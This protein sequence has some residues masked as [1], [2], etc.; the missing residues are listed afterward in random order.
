MEI[1]KGRSSEL[2]IDWEHEFK[3]RYVYQADDKLLCLEPKVM[4][5]MSKKILEFG[6]SK[7]LTS[8][9]KINHKQGESEKGSETSKDY[10]K[11]YLDELEKLKEGLTEPKG[12]MQI[13][14]ISNTRKYKLASFNSS[15]GQSCQSK[16]SQLPHSQNCLVAQPHSH[17]FGQ[18]GGGSF[19]MTGEE[20]APFRMLQR[21][22]SSLFQHRISPDHWR[23]EK[24]EPTKTSFFPDKAT[25]NRITLALQDL[26]RKTEFQQI[27][28]FLVSENLKTVYREAITKTGEESLLQ[29]G[30]YLN[31]VFDL[32]ALFGT[33]RYVRFL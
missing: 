17:M 31:K 4:S 14:P 33:L 8:F 27:P 29:L 13:E 23:S 28:G 19:Q 12:L 32:K 11:A 24:K 3:L 22:P 18:F 5:G 9:F 10:N 25:H 2:K 30:R 6:K 15:I 26:A 1:V 7:R 20:V 16:L 21:Q